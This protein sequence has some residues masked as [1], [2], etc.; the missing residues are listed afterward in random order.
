MKYLI[1]FFCLTGFTFS[2]E[3]QQAKDALAEQAIQINEL[4]KVNKNLTEM[5]NTFI[6]ELQAIKNPS[7]ELIVI[8]KKYKI[9]PEIKQ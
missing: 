9:Y 4:R 8:M 3:L 1:L 6:Q 5:T 7:E 2:Q